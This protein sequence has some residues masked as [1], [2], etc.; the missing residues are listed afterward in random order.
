MPSTSSSSEPAMKNG[1][2]MDNTMVMTADVGNRRT[3]DIRCKVA[4][5]D[6]ETIQSTDP[7]S[8]T[9][10][11]NDKGSV[12][13]AP[14]YEVP[15]GSGATVTHDF[16]DVQARL[17]AVDVNGEEH[18]GTGRTT[19]A[20]HKFTQMNV[21]FTIPLDQIKSLTFQTRPFDHVVDFKNCTLDPKVKTDVSVTAERK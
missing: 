11:S 15:G 7:T 17:I 9:S 5:G 18:V 3:M 20:T 8:S 12:A 16:A 14:A 10:N 1:V 4:A 19:N 13:I 2:P 21:V 6:W